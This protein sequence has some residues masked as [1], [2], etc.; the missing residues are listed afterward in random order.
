MSRTPRDKLYGLDAEFEP[1]RIFARECLLAR[2]LVER[3][4]RFIELTCPVIEG[5]DR[6]DAHSGLDQKPFRKCPGGGS[7]DRGLAERSEIARAI[8][9]D[10]WS[11]GPANLAALRLPKART[12]GTTIRSASR[13]G[14]PAAESRAAPIY[15][16]TDEYGYKVVENRCDIHDLHATMLHLLGVDHKRLTYRFSGRDFRLTDVYGEVLTDVL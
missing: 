8:G 6:W 15:G 2:R 4:V 14:W 7:A 10:A 11:C 13:C 16:A 1:T 3:G 12:A 9:G 5:N